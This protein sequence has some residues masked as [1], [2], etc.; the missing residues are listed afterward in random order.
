MPAGHAK[1]EEAKPA[2]RL[3]AKKGEKSAAPTPRREDR[4]ILDAKTRA[5]KALEATPGFAS[6]EDAASWLRATLDGDP[7][8]DFLVAAY[9]QE[10]NAELTSDSDKLID[11]SASL[12][13]ELARSEFQLIP[14]TWPGW[15]PTR[16]E[17]PGL[18]IAAAFLSL[19]AP[20]WYNML[21][22]LASLRPLLAMNN[23]LHK[24][25]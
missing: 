1:K 12:K 6:R 2:T 19:G 14:E 11:H 18:L 20:F 21:K 8:T 3:N 9:E 15:T 10:L 17:L 4:E 24:Q 13:R 16:R 25:A 23:E 22:K 5:S 7:A